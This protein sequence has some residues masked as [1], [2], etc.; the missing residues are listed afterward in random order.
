MLGP[1]VLTV[2]VVGFLVTTWVS[3]AVAELLLASPLYVA[4][5]GSLPPGSEDVVTAATPPVSVDVPTVVA[6]L[7]NVTVPVTPVGSVAVKVTDWPGVEGF[8]EE[9][10]VTAGV[11]LATTWM[12]VAVA[13]LLVVS[14]LYVAVMGS[15]PAGSEDVVVA[16]TPPVSVDVPNVVAPLVNVTVPVTP[17]GSV[18]VKVTDWPGVEGF[19]E[20]TRVTAGVI[21]ATT[22]V[23]VAVA[24]LLLVSPLYVAVMGSLPVGSEDVVVAATPPVSVDVPKDVA[25][26][27]NV[28]VPVTPLGSVAVNVTDCPGVEGFTEETRVTAGVVLATTWVSVPVAELLFP[29]PL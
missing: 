12:S 27:V 23:S 16:A 18:A 10:R 28:T 14:P 1:E 7:V 5:I 21:L 15:L 3:V 29:S 2:I 19:N 11:V 6:P 25:P 9:I 13:E 20:E 22:W 26:L 8:N 24:E 4:V 17:V